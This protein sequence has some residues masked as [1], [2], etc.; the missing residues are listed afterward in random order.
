MALL[1]IQKLGESPCF[2]PR[3]HRTRSRCINFETNYYD[4]IIATSLFPLLLIALVGGVYLAASFIAKDRVAIA[5]LRSS[6]VGFAVRSFVDS[7]ASKFSACGT[8]QSWRE[9]TTPPPPP[10]QPLYP[11]CPAPTLFQ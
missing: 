8:E 9:E 4:Q 6:C 11:V 7:T 3:T 2:F 5:A 10:A 1:L